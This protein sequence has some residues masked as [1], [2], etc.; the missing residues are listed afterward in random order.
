MVCNAK[1]SSQV[2]CFF[3]VMNS[4]FVSRLKIPTSFCF[5]IY[6]HHCLFIRPHCSRL[7]FL[8]KPAFMN[9]PLP[10]QMIQQRELMGFF[11]PFRL[12]SP[13]KGTAGW[14]R[15]FPGTLRELL[16]FRFN[17]GGRG[18][19]ET[20]TSE[21]PM[22]CRCGVALTV[23]PSSK[24]CFEMSHYYGLQFTLFLGGK[25]LLHI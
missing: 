17:G 13:K 25:V 22:W 24:A 14:F 8:V 4:L 6:R 16:C 9:T 19:S 3:P 12:F 20:R 1:L 5:Q 15:S 2:V 23:I 10:N 21:V 18:V 11:Q 7:S